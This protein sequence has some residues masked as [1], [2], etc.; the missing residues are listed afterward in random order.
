MNDANAVVREQAQ[1]PVCGM[2]VDPATAAHRV[3]HDGTAYYFCGADCADRFRK[4]PQG[5]LAKASARGGASSCCGGGSTAPREDRKST[6]LNS[7][8]IQKSRMPSS[9]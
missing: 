7:S 9:A 4:D 5:V 6:R 3:E 1:D 2:E 8:H